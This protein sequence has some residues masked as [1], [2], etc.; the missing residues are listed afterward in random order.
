MTRRLGC[1]PS[2]EEKLGLGVWFSKSPVPTSGD[3]P[4]GPVQDQGDSS[5]CTG[6]A[7]AVAI[8]ARMPR[9]PT[10]DFA[11][12]PSRLFPY[13][14]GRALEHDAEADNGA[15]L[16][17]VIAFVAKHGIPR[18]SVWP[19]DL[20]KL[21]TR[22]T[23]DVFQRALDQALIKGAHRIT[24]SGSARVV[25]VKQALALG[26]PVVWG[27][28]VDAAFM[29]LAPHQVW[30]GLG[31]DPR[32][33]HAMVLHRFDGDT[34]WTRSSWTAGFA[35]AGSARI[36]AEAVASKHARDFWIVET[37]PEYSA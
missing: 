20:S 27:T 1:I 33:G 3:V 28:E 2:H 12:L 25:Q 4:L 21:L 6:N 16:A 36:S 37:A 26:H 15:Q 18:E 34:F 29:D 31:E 14:G 17:D 7:V 32:G 24:T 19:F 13:Y 30:P 8:Q 10:G 35:D 22:P 5:S 11:E 9:T 23:L